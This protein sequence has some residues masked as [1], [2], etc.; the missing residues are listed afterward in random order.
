MLVSVEVITG[1]GVSLELPLEDL[2]T[3]G[4]IVKDIGGLD[5]VKATLVSSKFAQRDG[6]QYNSSQR[7]PRNI[8]IKLGIEPD[9][10]GNSVE[11]LRKNL[12]DFFMPKIQV[13]LRFHM[14]DGTYVDIL[15]MVESCESPLFVQEP[16]ADISLMCFNPD[17]YPPNSVLFDG[18]SATDPDG[19]GLVHVYPGSVE[20]G[21]LFSVTVIRDMAGFTIY[22]T[23][24]DGIV[25]K[26]VFAQ[27]V[28]VNDV[29][30]INTS[31]GQKSITVTR[32]GVTTSYLYAMP[33]DSD[34]IELQPGDNHIRVYS[35]VDPF[36]YS[37][38]YTPKY[39]GL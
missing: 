16:V 38:E 3:G 1:Q 39:G 18:V 27:Q 13:T 17:F 26:L 4:Y 14:D 37:I 32:G 21:I 28:F 29:V 31:K 33:P 5:P 36:P 6:A 9:Y 22:H 2:D 10:I 30:K 12:Y 11:V 24:R 20:T 25:R 8:T 15:G 23:P 35:T 34:W 19:L 7:D